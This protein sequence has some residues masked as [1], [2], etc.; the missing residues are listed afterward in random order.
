MMRSRLGNWPFTRSKA[1]W[2]SS[3]VTGRPRSGLSYHYA[4]VIPPPRPR[5]KFM[6]ARPE[7]SRACPWHGTKDGDHLLE[8]WRGAAT[9]VSA[10]IAMRMIPIRA[11]FHVEH[12]GLRCWAQGTAPLWLGACG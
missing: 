1:P 2:I 7:P 8:R 11:M 4:S 3:R 10:H 5:K 12:R 9:L 6:A